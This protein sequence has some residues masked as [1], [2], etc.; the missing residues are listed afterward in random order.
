MNSVME[1]KI[2]QLTKM[3]AELIRRRPKDGEEGGPVPKGTEGEQAEGE[4][5][6]SDDDSDNDDDKEDEKAGDGDG[7]GE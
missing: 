4:G 6:K 3:T 1:Q 2:D 7:D 5:D